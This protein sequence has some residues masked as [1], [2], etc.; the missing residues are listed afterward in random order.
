MIKTIPLASLLL[1]LPLASLSAS[2]VKRPNIIVILAD[3]LG[4]GELGCYG[5]KDAPTPNLDAMAKAGARFT[6]GYASCPVCSPTRAGLMTGKYQQRFGY[7]NNI[8]QSWEIEHP[9]LMGLPVEEKTI[10]DRLKSVGYRTACIGKW[11]LGAHENFHPQNRGFDEF[12]GFLEGGRAYLTDDDPGNFYLKSTPPFKEVRFKENRNAPIFRGRK[13]VEEKEYLTDAFTR[14]ALQFVDAKPEQP[15]FLYLAYN[16]V[17]TPITPCARWEAKLKHLENPIRRTVASMM[18]AMDENI[19]KLRGHL[20]E[21]GIADNTLLVFLSDNGGSPGGHQTAVA[22]D[23]ENYSLNTPLR[24]YKGECWEGGIRVPYMIE[25]PGKISP[26]IT[27]DAPVTSLDVLPTALA[28]A[29]TSPVEK[30]DGADLLPFLSGVKT[31]A[32]HDTLFWRF[33]IYKA[34]RKGQMKLVKRRNEPDQLFDLAVDQ[35]ES[36]NIAAERPEVL[37][38]LNRDLAAWENEMAPPR[39]DQK[40]PLR[41]DGR[42][43]FG[44]LFPNGNAEEA[45]PGGEWPSAWFRSK[46]CV[47]WVKGKSVSG[48][49]SLFIEDN[50]EAKQEPGKWSSVTGK[51]TPGMSYSLKWMWQHTQ[52]KKVTAQIRFFDQAGKFIESKSLATDGSNQAF[53]QQHLTAS[54]PA[55]AATADVLFMR[56]A[57]GSGSAWID[58]VVFEEQLLK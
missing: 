20:R 55:G 34:V 49:H 57:D 40:R 5:G 3:D 29:R 47:K 27:S 38:E 23:F 6:S 39:W 9:E 42:P 58:D 53:E 2:E 32:P 11:H 43:L 22:P 8:G 28:A 36:K 48:R 13:I 4:Y 41:P 24:G 19:G 37:A 14:E 33:H 31:E 30:A 45:Q 26:G 54:A 46:T 1:S 16:A 52:A 10:A 44:S 21:R 56:A 17:H 12:F 25:W 15:F 7:E 51:V 50:P 35:A 18:A